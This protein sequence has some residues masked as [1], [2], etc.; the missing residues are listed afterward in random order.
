M[1]AAMTNICL[2]E[3]ASSVDINLTS[4]G[5]KEVTKPLP[6]KKHSADMLV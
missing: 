5:G 6:L 1:D 4:G 3:S 2:T